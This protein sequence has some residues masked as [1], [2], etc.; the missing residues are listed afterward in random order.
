M[1]NAITDEQRR[2]GSGLPGG[3]PRR[4]PGLVP[5]ERECYRDGD[6]EPAG[7]GEPVGDVEALVDDRDRAWQVAEGMLELV[8][9]L[10]A[11]V[12]AVCGAGDHFERILV[13]A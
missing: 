1:Q 6:E 5:P 12:L 9:L 8:S 2:V 3:A 11:V 10:S 7:A 13:N 4:S